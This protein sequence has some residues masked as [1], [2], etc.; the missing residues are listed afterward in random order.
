MS[1]CYIRAVIR[2]A[3]IA[4]YIGNGV[5]AVARSIRFYRFGRA[6]QNRCF[7]VRTRADRCACGGRA[8]VGIG[9]GYFVIAR[10]QTADHRRSHAVVPCVGVRHRAA[11][12]GHACRAVGCR[13]AAFVG[14]GSGSRQVVGRN[15]YTYHTIR[16]IIARSIACG[17]GNVGSHRNFGPRRYV[18]CDCQI[19]I[20]VIRGCYNCCQ[21]RNCISTIRTRGFRRN[22]FRRTLK[23]RCGHIV[24]G[25]RNF[26]VNSVAVGVVDENC[27]RVAAAEV[28]AI[29]VGIARKEGGCIAAV[30]AD[31]T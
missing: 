11:R 6:G 12:S 15:F 25:H 7:R 31:C 22:C 21:I 2:C 10:S 8:A 3:D 13:R 28:A 29:K 27:H 4:R 17:Q 24:D 30:V 5:A 19:G 9:D 20:A 14:C 23:D 26:A 1:D 18:L 16:R